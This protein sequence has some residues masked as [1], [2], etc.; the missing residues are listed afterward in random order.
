MSPAGLISWG[1]L[2]HDG[3]H[4]HPYPP[5]SL[6][7]LINIRNRVLATACIALLILPAPLSMTTDEKTR[8][9]EIRERELRA[10]AS[11]PFRASISVADRFQVFDLFGGQRASVTGSPNAA[12]NKTAHEG[13]QELACLVRVSGS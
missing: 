12:L 2:A 13:R 5:H 7:R 3:A 11:Y 8:T 6:H 4:K 1:L 9:V 10:L